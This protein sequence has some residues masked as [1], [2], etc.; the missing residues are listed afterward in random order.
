MSTTR[1][2]FNNM[3]VYYVLDFEELSSIPLIVV[4][5]GGQSFSDNEWGEDEYFF[6]IKKAFY[7]NEPILDFSVKEFTTKD[8]KAIEKLAWS[9]HEK[10]MERAITWSMF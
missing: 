2:I 9:N 7:A 6:E 1:Q 5:S 8:R 3:E 10:E 4:C